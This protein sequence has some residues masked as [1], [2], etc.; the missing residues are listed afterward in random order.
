M[1]IARQM[2][3]NK[4][5]RQAAILMTII[6]RLFFATTSVFSQTPSPDQQTDTS[7]FNLT[8]PIED[9]GGCK[10]LEECANYCEDPVHYNG[11]GAYAKENGFY[12][13]DVTQY[14]TDEFW[15]D[16][17]EEIGCN[18]TQSCFDYC[19]QP[20]NHAACDTWAK[21]NDIPGGYTDEPDKPEYL[22]LAQDTLGCNSEDTC[23]T[24][25][26]NPA[27]AQSC[28]NFANQVGLLG[29]TETQGP[30]G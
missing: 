25:C 4:L 15:Q 9:L 16:A 30:N 18:S 2:L 22:T 10:N 6:S 20:E 29:G 12:K 23:L 24:F 13:D 26:D 27:N 14:A 7:S 17:Q 5:I 21:T 28:T 1:T 11:C 8:Y 19:S 3:S